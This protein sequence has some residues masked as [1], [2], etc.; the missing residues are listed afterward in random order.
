M[1]ANTCEYNALLTI[2]AFIDQLDQAAA[3]AETRLVLI[4]MLLECI[5]RSNETRLNKNEGELLPSQKAMPLRWQN[6][7]K[8]Q[9]RAEDERPEPAP[10]A[11]LRWEWRWV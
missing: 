4:A 5:L 11:I 10:W 1:S 7:E 6:K 3:R 2:G 8:P 9:A